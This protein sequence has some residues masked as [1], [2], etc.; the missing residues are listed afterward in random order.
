M[1]CASS[2]VTSFTAVYFRP[3]TG[4]W[5]LG[6]NAGLTYAH[7]GINQFSE[8]GAGS[9]NLAVDDQQADSLRGRLGGTVRFQGGLDVY[10]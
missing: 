1:S 8:T 2:I 6:P 10:C 5:V 4:G 9:V 7:L 3:P